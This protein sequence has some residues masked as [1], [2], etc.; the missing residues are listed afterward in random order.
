[1][2]GTVWLAIVVLLLVL[3]GLPILF[4]IRVMRRWRLTFCQTILLHGLNTFLNRILWRTKVN[5]PLPIADGQ[6]AIII[7]NHRS[8]FDPMFIAMTTGRLLH[9]M[10]AREYCVDWR[11]GW[12]FRLFGQIPAGRGGVDSAAIKHAI[13]LASAGELV[14]ML[15][16][17]RI[18]ETGAFLLPGRPGSVLV[19]LKAR[20]PIVPCYIEGAPYGGILGP[21]VRP[22]HV[23]V[24]VGDP[25]DLSEYYDRQKDPEM[26]AELT[27]R[28]LAA[29]AKLA[30]RDDYVPEVAGRRWSPHLDEMAE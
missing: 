24:M 10:V 16:E 20:V 4:T 13:R 7:A 29:I 2:S 18:N 30:G 26:M 17:G 1:M 11:L 12:F 25:I 8:S 9:W 23:R 27:K 28:C 21:F 6:G 14:G 15:P 5:R 19:A 22:A 3:I